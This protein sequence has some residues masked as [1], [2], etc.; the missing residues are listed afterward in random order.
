MNASLN[1]SSLAQDVLADHEL[2]PN[3]SFYDISSLGTAFLTADLDRLDGAYREL[4]R[5]GLVEQIADHVVRVGSQSRACF[6]LCK[7]VG[8][9][10]R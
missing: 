2:A 4:A 8:A 7:A 5:A 1:L 3:A 9:G 10:G 6:R